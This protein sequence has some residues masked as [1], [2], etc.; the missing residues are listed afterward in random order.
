ME[1]TPARN[2]STK[3]RDISASD[4]NS[5][6]APDNANAIGLIV[7]VMFFLNTK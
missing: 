5:E 2:I 4:I 7:A 6:S 1:T 3:Q